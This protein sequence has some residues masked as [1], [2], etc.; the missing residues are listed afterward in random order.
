MFQ[1][2]SKEFGTYQL[3]GIKKKDISNMFTLE[4]IILGFF[5]LLISIPIGYLFSLLMSSILMNIFQLKELVKIDF[6]KMPLILLGLY[7][8]IIGLVTIN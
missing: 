7:F 4:N 2:R 3:L 1:K 6:G 8:V 5:S